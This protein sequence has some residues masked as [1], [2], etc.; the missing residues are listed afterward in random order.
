MQDTTLQ[1]HLMHYESAVKKEKTEDNPNFW[2]IFIE[3]NNRRMCNNQI[4]MKMCASGFILKEKF[5]SQC[6][7]QLNSPGNDPICIEQ[8]THMW[9]F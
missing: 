7:T 1:N 5:L 8:E 4:P 6:H 3:P 2:S 9:E